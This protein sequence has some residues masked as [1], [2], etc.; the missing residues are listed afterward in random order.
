MKKHD[1]RMSGKIK[2]VLYVLI[3][4]IISFVIAGCNDIKN[5]QSVDNELKKETVKNDN[6]SILSEP[7]NLITY[8]D[9]NIL[10]WLEQSIFIDKHGDIIEKTNSI[11][12][13]EELKTSV[14]LKYVIEEK[15]HEIDLST[16]VIDHS[17]KG[18]QN[19]IASPNGKYVALEFNS[20][21]CHETVLIDMTNN[22]AK[23]LYDNE[24]SKNPMI[25]VSWKY[26]DDN[27]FAY[28]PAF[29]E[30]EIIELKMYNIANKSKKTICKLDDNFT[31]YS[32]MID[33][34]KDNIK[35]IDVYNNKLIKIDNY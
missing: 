15:I 22:T 26:D 24:S 23:M 18:V 1:Y 14:V 32:S 31:G 8:K 5:M 35:I 12:T 2:I 20:S 13:G 34:N 27:I 28:I 3:T 4:I 10:L 25:S 16:L 33:W 6:V 29:P 9:N 7:Q 21:D 30:E 11:Y 19:V 17:L